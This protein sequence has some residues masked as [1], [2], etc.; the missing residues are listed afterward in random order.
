MVKYFSCAPAPRL[1]T[2]PQ[3]LLAVERASS[4][5]RSRLLASVFPPTLAGGQKDSG[6]PRMSDEKTDVGKV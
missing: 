5:H 6:T 3:H 1:V 4:A 2:Q